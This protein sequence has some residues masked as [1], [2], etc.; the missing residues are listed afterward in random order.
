MALI[1][2][3]HLYIA[4]Y[5]LALPA[6]VRNCILQQELKN[7]ILIILSKQPFSRDDPGQVRS[8]Q[9]MDHMI[10]S[11]NPDM[12]EKHFCFPK[13]PHWLCHPLNLLLSRYCFF[14]RRY[15]KKTTCM[16]TVEL[17]LFSSIRLHETQRDSSTFNCISLNLSVTGLTL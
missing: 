2:F 3:G 9:A 16:H 8:G 5:K 17:Y 12:G 1:F 11:S 10:K 14:F 13:C 7:F 6:T 15:M 4:T